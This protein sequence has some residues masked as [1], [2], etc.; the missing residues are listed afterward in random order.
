MAALAAVKGI[1]F[2]A[3][4]LLD[5]ILDHEK[6]FWQTEAAAR[7]Q[8]KMDVELAQELVCA[9]TLRGGIT[10]KDDAQDLCTQLTRRPQSR[11]DER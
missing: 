6:R 8:A 9:T 3:G 1:A 4:T 11:E 5:V 7:H 10:T 2:D